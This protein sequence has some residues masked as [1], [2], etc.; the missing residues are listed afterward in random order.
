[1]ETTPVA[2]FVYNRPEHTFRTVEALKNNIL[3]DKTELFIF[4]DG[5]KMNASRDDLIKID[6]VKTLVSSLTGFKKIN[7]QFSKANKGLAASLI[8]GINSVL[9]KSETIIVLEDDILTSRYF[10][11]FCNDSLVKY[12]SEEK[13]MSVSGYCFPI[14]APPT[15]SYFLRTGACWGWA[16]WKRAWN[17]FSLDAQSY[18]DDIK[19]ENRTEEFN[20]SGT[21]DYTGML[22][23]HIEGKIS[24][25]AACW[26]ACVFLQN[27][28]TLYPPQALTLNTGMDGSGTHYKGAVD[29]IKEIKFNE[30]SLKS[31]TLPDNFEVDENIRNQIKNYFGIENEFSLKQK[32][33]NVFKKFIFT[34]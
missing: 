29:K 4:A 13:V 12:A 32:V 2:L 15:H 24:S 18:L 14:E 1:M 7:L 28:L 33:K 34:R 8:Q 3:A 26:Y 9:E 22:Q 20:F 17:Y 11:S 21:Y 5:A 31:W 10:L 23:Q 27:G 16:T 25:W 19:S 30:E 6:K